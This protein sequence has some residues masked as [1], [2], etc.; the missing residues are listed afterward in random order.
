MDNDY[1]KRWHVLILCSLGM[2]VMSVSIQALTP[3]NHEIQKALHINFSALGFLMGSISIPG[4]FLSLPGG[5]IADRWGERA[6]LFTGFI[7]MIAGASLF[8]LKP[9][10]ALL[11][12]S[13]ILSGAGC[14]F[15]SVLLP[16]MVTP[17][18]QGRSLGMAMGIFNTALPLGSIV[19]LSFF[20]QLGATYGFFDVFWIPVIL[21]ALTLIL[22][23]LF[24]PS[25]SAPES[26]GRRIIIPPLKNQIWILGLVTLFA[27]MATMG[28]VTIAPTY[29]TGLGRYSTALV[30]V[31]LS[32]V[33]WGNLLLSPLAG[34]L[35][36]RH[37]MA[38]LLLMSGCAFQGLCLMLI[39]QKILPL[40]FDL[41]LFAVAAGI[42]ITPIY[43]LVPRAVH[44]TQI[45]TA[46]G[47]IISSM[48]VGCLTGP[49]VAGFAVDH[50]NGFNGGFAALGIFSLAGAIAS[51][52]LA[53]EICSGDQEADAGRQ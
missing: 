9:G 29:F 15:L 19:T 43:I 33:L 6:V 34:Y 11:C 3:L 22:F 32:A 46:F 7:L 23:V 30:G 27:N 1:S 21:T 39:P 45:N 31:M 26:A 40:A 16:G 51:A 5:M 53:K 49:Y 41:T 37:R 18:F 13:R 28:Y 10:Y 42:I 25:K 48:M 36:T 44:S 14:I 52:M 4:I 20:G 50:C 24:L 47:I 2:A 38:K 17:C 12:A 8:A 35:T